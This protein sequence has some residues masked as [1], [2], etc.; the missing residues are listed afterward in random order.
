MRLIIEVEVQGV[1]P[2]LV[3]PH[4][5]AEHLLDDPACGGDLTELFSNGDDTSSAVFI[6]AEWG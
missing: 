1:D 3:D 4:E 5:V 2:R 6:G